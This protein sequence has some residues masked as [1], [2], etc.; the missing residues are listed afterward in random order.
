MENPKQLRNWHKDKHNLNIIFKHLYTIIS[1]SF[2]ENQYPFLDSCE[3]IT[4]RRDRIKIQNI[5]MD[6]MFCLDGLII[7]KQIKS[8]FL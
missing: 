8:N 2:L 5:Y 7:I 6:G 1:P 4:D 3:K